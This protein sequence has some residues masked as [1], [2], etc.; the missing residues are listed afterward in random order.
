MTVLNTTTAQDLSL[1]ITREITQ[2]REQLGH[3]HGIVGIRNVLLQGLAGTEFPLGIP[4]RHLVTLQMLQ[5]KS[6]H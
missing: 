2:L 6:Q 1:I 4:A 3:M 5:F